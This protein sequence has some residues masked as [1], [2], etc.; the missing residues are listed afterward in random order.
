MSGLDADKIIFSCYAGDVPVCD[1]ETG[2]R[3]VAPTLI[4]YARQNEVA[5]CNCKRQCRRLNYRYRISQ[6]K[7]SD[8]VVEFARLMFY[9]E[10]TSLDEI[11]KDHLAL[12]VI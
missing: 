7:L 4:R 2:Y 1:P 12:E 3:C 10:N 5:N 11:R 8:L 9:H 6:A